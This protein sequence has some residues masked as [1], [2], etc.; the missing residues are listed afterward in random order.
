ML[1]VSNVQ[2]F[3][4]QNAIQGM[5]NPL[6]SWNKSTSDYHNLKLCENDIELA[7]KLIHGGSEHRKFLRQIFISGIVT[8]PWYWWK[9]YATYKVGTTENST[10]QMHTITKRFLTKDDFEVDEWNEKFDFL[11]GSLNELIADYQISKD[12]KVW[13]ELIQLIP[14]SF[15]YTRTISLNYEIFFN[16]LIQ[17][18]NHKLVEWREFLSELFKHLPYAKTF[19][20]SY[21]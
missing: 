15:K 13:R 2:S 11:L 8:A 20:E 12:K 1:R 18:K 14:G 19:F 16:M 9:E 5:R 3:N 10:S 7:K 4:W 17:R 21:I 6:Q